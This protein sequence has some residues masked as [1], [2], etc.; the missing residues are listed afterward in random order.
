MYVPGML[1]ADDP[2]YA[3]EGSDWS[4]VVNK[5]DITGLASVSYTGGWWDQV[6]DNTNPVA[7]TTHNYS[8]Y[9]VNYEGTDNMGEFSCAV[10]GWPDG[11]GVSHRLRIKSGLVSF[12]RIVT[13]SDG[14]WLLT[15][16]N[17]ISSYNLR[18]TEPNIYPTGK[19]HIGLNDNPDYIH[20]DGYIELEEGS[21]YYVFLYKITPDW[22]TYND[23]KAPQ[24][25][26]SKVTDNPNTNIRTGFHGGGF[27]MFGIRTEYND[28]NVIDLSYRSSFF[29]DDC[30]RKDIAHI[31]WNGDK[32]IVKQ[33]HTGPII[34]ED[35][36]IFTLTDKSNGPVTS[37]GMNWYDGAG[38]YE[39]DPFS[40]ITNMYNTTFTGYTKSLNDGSSNEKTGSTTAD[41]Y[42]PKQPSQIE[43]PDIT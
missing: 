13:N 42:L 8:Y 26:I 6:T 18:I 29:K 35:K 11:G 9:S 4:Y 38:S 39:N 28:L 2:Y 37:W 30:Y 21:D 10:I 27:G 25:V 22:S 5:A 3:N 7:V 40:Q 15:G 1:E 32:F 20:N 31:K 33:L 24:L 12:L 34:M 41:T 43:N 19:L 16:D 14:V 36:P 17:L 23:C